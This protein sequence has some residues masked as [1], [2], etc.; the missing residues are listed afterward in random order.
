MKNLFVI[1][2]IVAVITLI[3]G[4]ITQLVGHSL[5]ISAA[6]WNELT[7]TF[8]LFAAVFGIWNIVGK[9]E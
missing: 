3:M 1:A 8:L 6:G 2:L 7:Q 4:I 5:I 9:K